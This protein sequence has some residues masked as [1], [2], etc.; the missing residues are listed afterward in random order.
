M[1]Q[2]LTILLY[3]LL[4][5]AANVAMG[6]FA[7]LAVAPENMLDILFGWQSML[8]KMWESKN[9]IVKLLEK[10]LGGCNMCLLHMVS[11]VS[12]I[13]Y[14]IAS[15][16]IGH[17]WVTDYVTGSIWKVVI[18]IIWY[19]VFVSIAWFISVKINI[20]EKAKEA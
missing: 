19:I 6:R 7:L 9:K 15:T 12:Y 10:M 17:V 1:Q 18:N 2:L 3:S 8:N 20:N 5:L 16:K 13:M 14:Y 11:I 4:F